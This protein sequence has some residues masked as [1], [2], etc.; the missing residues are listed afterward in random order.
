MTSFRRIL[1]TTLLC[2]APATVLAHQCVARR[3]A[4]HSAPAAAGV[5]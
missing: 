2:A 5:V 3:E 1:V 4:Q